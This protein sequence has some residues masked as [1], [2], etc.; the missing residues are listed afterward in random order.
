MSNHPSI[1]NNFLYYIR[2]YNIHHRHSHYIFCN[3]QY[4]ILFYYYK[5]KKCIKNKINFN[6]TMASIDILSIN[7]I[8]FSIETFLALTE[9]I[10]VLI[11]REMTFGTI[12]RL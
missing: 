8:K 2:G 7:H 11:F 6:S 3:P 10:L 4:D 5:F 9:A 12:I 1:G